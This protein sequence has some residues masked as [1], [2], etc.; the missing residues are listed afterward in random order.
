MPNSRSKLKS[1]HFRGPTQVS[2]IL[3][4]LLILGAALWG[5][6][7]HA[8]VT[9][10]CELILGPGV[11]SPVRGPER[12]VIVTDAWE[13]TNGVAKTIEVTARGLREQGR[14]VLVLEAHGLKLPTFALPRYPSIQLAYGALLPSTQDELMRQIE[15]FRPDALHIATEGPLG[16]A[17]RALALRQGWSFTTSFHTQYAY[18]ANLYSFG[19]VSTNLVF[20]MLRRFHAPARRTLVTNARMQAELTDHGFKNTVIWGRGVDLNEYR[21]NDQARADLENRR[22]PVWDSLEEPE[23]EAQRAALLAGPVSIYLGRVAREKNV[24]AFLRT[25]LPG[26]KLVVG[27]GPQGKT[28]ASDRYLQELKAQFGSGPDVIFVGEQKG[29]AKLDFLSLADVMVFPSRTDTFGNV[30]IE[31]MAIGV[32]VAAYSHTGSSGVIEE[33]VTGALDQDLTQAVRRARSLDHAR[34]A[35]GAQKFSPEAALRQFVEALVP[36]G[37][38]ENPAN[39][40]DR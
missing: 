8:K 23:R 35:Q 26:V 29:Q 20:K 6:S 19:L 25:P 17:M 4:R 5:L 38:L 28:L 13:Q 24:E 40:S 39:E 11:V 15:A 10:G 36:I 34:V 2:R 7:G 3:F 14:Q 32:P 16:L 1:H 22:G 27:P 18:Y 9:P 33:N 30:Q 37:T 12:I 31:A 21:F